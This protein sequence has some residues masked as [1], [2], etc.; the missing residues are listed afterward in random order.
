MAAEFNYDLIVIGSG[1][2]GYV[3]AIRASQL[4][5][6]TVVIEKDKIGGVCL[7]TGCIPS[8]SLIHQAGIYR[9]IPALRELGVA[10]DTANFDY[11]NVYDNSRKAAETLSRGIESS[12]KK[13]NIDYIFATATITGINKISLNNGKKLTGKNILIATGSQPREIPGFG[14][15]ESTVLSSTGALML[16]SLPEKLVILGAGAVGI[17]FAHIFNAFGVEI[18]IVELLDRILPLEDEETVSVLYKSFRKRKIQISTAAKATDMQEKNGNIQVK[19]R[20]DREEILVET[21]KVLI[22]AGR[23]PNTDNIGLENVGIQTDKGF[24]PAGDYYQTAIP[25]IFAIGDVI[26]TPLLAHVASKEGIIAV[27]YM[28]G[29]KPAAAIDLNTIP[30]AIYSEPQIGSFGYTEQKAQ[31]ENI[32]YAKTVFRYVGS[33]K[34]ITEEKPE[35]LLKIL[36]HPDTHEILGAHMVGAAATEL[37]HELL[38]AKY[39][40]LL[41][42]DVADMIHA[43]PTISEVVMECCRQIEGWNIHL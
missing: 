24:I 4:G 10:V 29:R 30:S 40:K 21:E 17:E 18:Q 14:I 12:F 11:I 26:N 43:H 33:G 9:S 32:E 1:P 5:M 31:A 35:G 28:A 22:A 19:F 16:K 13:H 25:G 15:N 23:L 38:L 6:K 37:I 8:K 2:G 27:E 34:S 3:A 7:N 42:A 36:F 20:K 41:P 39:A